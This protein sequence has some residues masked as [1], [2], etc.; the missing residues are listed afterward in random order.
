MYDVHGM[1]MSRQQREGCCHWHVV[2]LPVERPDP[3]PG[4]TQKGIDVPLVI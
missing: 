2:S 3:V 4:S 1:K